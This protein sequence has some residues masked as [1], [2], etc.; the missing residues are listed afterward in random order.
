MLRQTIDNTE[1]DLQTF[2][3]VTLSRADDWVLARNPAL[4]GMSER[5]LAGPQY[6]AAIA[7]SPAGL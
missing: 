4:P 6:E 5:R 1:A 7:A 2:S 3:A